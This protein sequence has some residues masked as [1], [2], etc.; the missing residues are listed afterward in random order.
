MRPKTVFR[1]LWIVTT[2]LLLGAEALGAQ[3]RIPVRQGFWI[4]VGLAG[5]WSF[6]DEFFEDE[7]KASPGGFLRL[8][9]SPSQQILVGADIMAWGSSEDDLDI[10]R[11]AVMLTVLFY[12]SALG[13]FFL[14]GGVGFAVRATEQNFLVLDNGFPVPA[15]VDSEDSGLG[16][17]AALGFDVQLARNFFLTPTMDLLF[18]Q[19]EGDTALLLLLGIGATW[20]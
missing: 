14:K 18:Q 9:G 8:G 4:S 3:H 5:G 20:H 1:T 2:V 15:S 13:G 11:G 17:G 7:A 12:P 16:L 6:D 10:T 19:V